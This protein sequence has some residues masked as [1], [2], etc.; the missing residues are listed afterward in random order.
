MYI[1]LLLI[2]S[3]SVTLDTVDVNHILFKFLKFLSHK[4]Y[5]KC[6]KKSEHLFY[7]YKI[8]SPRTDIVKVVPEVLYIV[9]VDS[10]RQQFYPRMRQAGRDRNILDSHR[11]AGYFCPMCEKTVV[12]FIAMS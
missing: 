5:S 4:E 2:M 9:M 6:Y 3:I 10:L 11:K 8:C 12:R 7:F 1:S